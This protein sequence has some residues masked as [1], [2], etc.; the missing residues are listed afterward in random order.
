MPLPLVIEA[1][2]LGRRFG[3]RTVLEG[4]SI[5]VGQGEVF[6]VV[7]P[8]GAGKTTLLQ[9]LAGILRPSFGTCRVLGEDVRRSADRVQAQVGYMSQGF[10]LY[11][12]LTV[13]ENISFAAGIRDVPKAAFEARKTQLL[14]MAGLE[15][16]ETRR[17][18]ALSGGMRKKLA[19]CAN[20]IHEPPLLILDEPSLGVDPLS[21]RELWRMLE[22]AKAVGRSI[23]FATSYMDEADSSDRVLLL[24]DG[25]PLAIGS[26]AELRTSARQRVYRVTTANPGA[27]ESQLTDSDAVLSFQKRTLGEYRVQL[28]EAK[29]QH[30]P[31]AKTVEIAQPTMEDVF[32][33][34]SAPLGRSTSRSAASKIPTPTSDTLVAAQA[35]TQRF[36]SFVAVDNVSLELKAGEVLGLLGPNGA[37]KT[38]LMRILCGLLSPTEGRAQVAGLDVARQSEQVRAT[39][40]YVSQKFSLFTDLTS[41]ENL[42][43]FTRAYGVSPTES[44][45]RIAWACERAGFPVGEEGLVRNL[46]SALRQRLA[47]AC[48]IVH[49]PRVLFL[50]EPTSGVDPLSRFRFWRLISMLAADGVAVIVST[51]YLEEATYCDR[52]GLMMDGRMIALGSL[53]ML[54]AELGLTDA[55]VE[56][57]FMGFI[58]RERKRLTRAA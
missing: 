36:G 23:I 49:R 41:Q 42:S 5:D 12:R 37:G 38:T 47:L 48:A 55:R 45:S 33:V 8:D 35:I 32:T 52:L 11:D 31:A 27:L 30:F 57:V 17:E 4:V 16:F 24:R 1:E 21:R 54:E 3:A 7:G 19:L 28:A 50:D 2:G 39:I 53:S 43:F 22:G 14:K 51:H 10:S 40:G 26:P 15:R 34:A 44:P 46:S 56:D 58:D 9:I 18:G 6:G 25:R 20:L 13:A 29:P